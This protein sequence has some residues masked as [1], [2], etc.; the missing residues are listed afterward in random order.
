ML[1]KLKNFKNR[2]EKLLS[3]ESDW[4]QNLALS[5]APLSVIVVV[6][7]HNKILYGSRP[8]W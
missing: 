1:L 4:S 3:I 7:T 6:G 8:I 2:I 5:P